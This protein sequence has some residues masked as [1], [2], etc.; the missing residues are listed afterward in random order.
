M[1][2]YLPKDLLLPTYQAPYGPR[3]MCHSVTMVIVCTLTSLKHFPAAHLPSAYLVPCIVYPMLMV[4]HMRRHNLNHCKHIIL[5]ALRWCNAYM[6]V[7]A[8]RPPCSGPGLMLH[9]SGGVAYSSVDTTASMHEYDIFGRS[10]SGRNMNG[11]SPTSPSHRM[12]ELDSISSARS[13][14][15]PFS[16]HQGEP[17]SLTMTKGYDSNSISEL[18]VMGPMTSI[19]DPEAMVMRSMTEKSAYGLL[20]GHHHPLDET[21]VS[22]DSVSSNM[23]YSGTLSALNSLAARADQSTSSSSYENTSSQVAL[24]HAQA[25]LGQ[26]RRHARGPP[27][28]ETQLPA[29]SGDLRS[30]QHQHHQHQECGTERV[31]SWSLLEALA[32]CEEG[33]W[34]QLQIHAEGR[35]AA[36]KQVW[37]MLPTTFS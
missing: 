15:Q 35:L 5:A 24:S 26:P 16:R 20:A 36:A 10:T 2:A 13:H 28:Q 21:A 19:E 33:N 6:N 37:N 11:F 23:S 22:L 18:N 25:A 8:A 17:H 12:P 7:R 4:L 31:D 32:M 34:P 14:G 1:H 9:N 30:H 27:G 3:A 29:T